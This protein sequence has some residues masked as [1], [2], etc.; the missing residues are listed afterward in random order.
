MIWKL[1]F[2]R[3][4]NFRLTRC[5]MR[6][7]EW[8]SRKIEASSFKQEWLS[9]KWK[10]F[11]FKQE[12]LGKKLNHFSSKQEPSTFLVDCCSLKV[13]WSSKKWEAP[14]VEVKCCGFN[15]D[16]CY[17]F[18]DLPE[19]VPELCCLIVEKSCLCL[20]SKCRCRYWTCAFVQQR[21]FLDQLAKSK[22]YR[23]AKYSRWR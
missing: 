13:N 10:S 7:P 6:Q 12:W 22:R 2:S 5:R 15:S 17:F 9:K 21:A 14:R 23:R 4:K 19:A 8:L 16:C 1:L 11:S 3:D 18:H 20:G